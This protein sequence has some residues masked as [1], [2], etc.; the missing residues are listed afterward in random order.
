M[1]TTCS[2]NQGSEFLF[3]Q[4]TVDWLEAAFPGYEWTASLH[5]GVLYI[6]NET[7]SGRWGMQKS[8]LRV[9]KRWIISAG[10][11]IL[12]RFNMPY[13]FNRAASVDAKRDFT[14]DIVSEKWTHDRR[15]YNKA[16]KRWKA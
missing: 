6:K 11:E 9:D 12:D 7:L 10:G 14:G 16:E 2:A 5:E 4:Q 3:A 15:Y 13:R 8:A 1:I